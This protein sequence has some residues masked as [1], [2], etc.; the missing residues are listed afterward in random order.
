MR[1]IT[2]LYS[3]KG[4]V[5]L[6]VGSIATYEHFRKTATGEGFSLP[7]GY[8]DIFAFHSDYKF[9]HPGFAGHMLFHNPKACYGDNLIRVDYTKW[10]SGAKSYIYHGDEAI[11]GRFHD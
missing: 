10:I 11:R 3:L 1:T 4:R 6:R 2:E 7:D 8:D 9:V 5:Y